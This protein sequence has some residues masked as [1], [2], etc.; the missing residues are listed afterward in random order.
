MFVDYAVI[1]YFITMGVFVN[2]FC[3][4]RTLGRTSDLASAELFD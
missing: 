1:G 2:V 3:N 4:V